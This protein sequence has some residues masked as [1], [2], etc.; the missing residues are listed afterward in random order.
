[1]LLVENDE[2]SNKLKSPRSKNIETQNYQMNTLNV[3]KHLNSHMNVKSPKYR[4]LSN[5][6]VI[7]QDRSS[8]LK[9]KS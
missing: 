9:R 5:Q 3:D 6:K 2:D 8:S 7:S 1:M 4:D